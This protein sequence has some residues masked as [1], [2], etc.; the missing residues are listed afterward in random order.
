MSEAQ[1]AVRHHRYSTGCSGFFQGCSHKLFNC[2]RIFSRIFYLIF[3]PSLIQYF[4]VSAVLFIGGGVYTYF[5]YRGLGQ[6]LD[7]TCPEAVIHCGQCTNGCNPE[8]FN[9]ITSCFCQCYDDLSAG[10]SLTGSEC[11]NLGCVRQNEFS[12]IVPVLCVTDDLSQKI[13]DGTI[14]DVVRNRVCSSARLQNISENNKRLLQIFDENFDHNI[15]FPRKLQAISTGICRKDC[16][17]GTNLLVICIF[18][19][20]QGGVAFIVALCFW[21]FEK[22][23]EENMKQLNWAEVVLGFFCKQF[24]PQIRL[25]Q[26]ANLVQFVV[27][28]FQSHLTVWFP[29]CNIS[30]VQLTFYIVAAVWVFQLIA[31][32]AASRHLRPPPYFYSPKKVGHGIWIWFNRLLRSLGP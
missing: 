19:W 2:C 23:G 13:A 11:A 4:I 26:I 29:V 16:P 9:S 20:V 21:Y 15:G 6:F 1:A 10:I 25:L 3:Y 7:A 30:T 18:Y 17:V 27:L 28:F 22:K 32:I 24:P 8:L 31:G 12:T 14:D 5:T